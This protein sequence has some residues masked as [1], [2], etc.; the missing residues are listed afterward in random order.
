MRGQVVT[1]AALLLL[2]TCRLY[3]QAPKDEVKSDFEKRFGYPMLADELRQMHVMPMPIHVRAIRFTGSRNVPLK[4]QA[5]IAAELLVS[6][7]DLSIEDL[8][9]ERV[10]DGWQRK[11]YFRAV[12]GDPRA[13]ALKS[14]GDG[15][16]AI[17]VIHVKTGKRYK[18]A[19]FEWEGAT[20]FSPAE[21]SNMM[22]LRPGDVFDTSRIRFGLTAVGEAYNAKHYILFTAVPDTL[23]DE[24]TGEITL[25]IDVDEGGDFSN[26]IASGKRPGRSGAFHYDPSTFLELM[27]GEGISIPTFNDI[28]LSRPALRRFPARRG[29]PSE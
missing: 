28:Q 29:K 11:G 3:A 21:L 14:V 2:V 27:A 17:A 4:E 16:S 5:A 13:A 8:D 7:P 12:V 20:V 15:L 6:K 24:T 22:P 25:K 26:F 9:P 10:R 23:I 19:G 18:L 1:F